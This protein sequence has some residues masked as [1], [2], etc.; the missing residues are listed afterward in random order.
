[1]AREEN[2][3]SVMRS[4]LS[5]SGRSHRIASHLAVCDRDVRPV[6]RGTAYWAIGQLGI[7]ETE[8]W[9]E[10]LQQCEELEQNK[11]HA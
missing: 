8:Q 7:K 3:C 1:M 2:H 5:K 10:R 11:K 4:L 9:L 6:I